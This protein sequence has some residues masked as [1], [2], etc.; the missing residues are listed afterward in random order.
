MMVFDLYG[1]PNSMAGRSR[2]SANG[3]P[4]MRQRDSAGAWACA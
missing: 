3:D 4:E 2:N 1:R